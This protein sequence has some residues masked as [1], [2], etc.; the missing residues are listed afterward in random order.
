MT[1]ISSVGVE[2]PYEAVARSFFDAWNAKDADAFA[3][4]FTEDVEF[5]TVKGET[6]RGRTEVADGHRALFAQLFASATLTCT[7]VRGCGI[8]DGVGAIDATWYIAEHVT[9]AGDH[10][11]RREG[12][13]LLI[14]REWDGWRPMKV[15]NSECT[16]A[17]RRGA[18]GALRWE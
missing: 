13:L 14:A 4:V 16:R 10:V 9:P 7:G 3:R 18:D 12:S 1:S 8:A 6:Q 2:A 15:L 11:P 17:Y 5:T